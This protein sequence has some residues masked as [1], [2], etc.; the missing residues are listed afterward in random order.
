MLNYFEKMNYQT[1]IENY[2]KVDLNLIKWFLREKEF[3]I[4]VKN[5]LIDKGKI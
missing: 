1:N 4:G 5:L 3:F 2:F